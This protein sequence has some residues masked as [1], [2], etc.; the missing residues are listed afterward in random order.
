M[1][2]RIEKLREG[3]HVEIYPVSLQQARLVT[4]SYKQTE[5]EPEVIRRSK[6]LANILD[7]MPI[8]IEEGEL[9]VGNSASKPMGAE[10]SFL[11]GTCSKEQIEELKYEGWG[12]SEEDVAEA[13]QLNEYWRGKGF[14]ARAGHIFDD[15]RM[16]PYMQSG[17]T[18]PPW[19]DR[20][21]GWGGIAGP[22]MS[23]GPNLFLVGTDYEKVLREGLN[24]TIE[25]AKN[26]LRNLRFTTADSAKKVYFLRAV[27]TVHQA[28]IRF[29]H[30]FSRLA[31]E[32]A[33]E[34]AD[35]TRKK[36]LE[37]IAESCRWV[38]ANPA[39]TF[40]EALQS[41]WFAFLL[42]ANQTTPGGRFDQ[43]MYPFYKGDVDGGKITDEQ[44]VELLQCLRIKCMQVI[45][46]PVRREQRDKGAGY[47]RWNNFVIG[48]VT[49]EGKDATNELT[50][51]L[52]E[53]ARTCPTPHHTITLRVHEGT[54][55]ALMV[56]ALEV[57][58]T[59]IGMPAFVGDQSY[60][61]YLLNE[62]VPLEVAR[63]YILVGCLD[64][65]LSRGMSRISAFPM[66]VVPKVFELFLNNGV[67]PR[68]GQQ[69]GPKTGDI[70][71]FESYDELK[72][73]WEQHLTHFLGIHAEWN[74]IFTLMQAEHFPFP[75]ESSLMA[76]G[77][78]V[79]R[80]LMERTFP[81]L[82]NGS[83]MNPVGMINV[84]DS[85]AAIKRVVFDEK[86]VTMKQLKAA[87][88][89]NWQG[90]Q[91]QEIHKM[92]LAVPKFGNDN[93]Y[94]DSI[95]KEMY[96]FWAE[97]TNTFDSVLGGKQKASA[98]SITAHVPG[99]ALTG[100]TPDGRYA[101]ESLAD[102][103]LSPVQ[104]RD[105]LGPTA[106]I[107]SAAKIDQT[108][109]QAALFNMK[110]HPSAMKSTED[111]TK[112]AALIKTYFSMG[113]KHVQFNVVSKETLQ[114]AQKHPEKH[115]DL[116]VRVA[117]YS[118]YFVQLNKTTQEEIIARSEQEQTA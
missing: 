66:F 83:V 116:I 40:A 95:A 13:E 69:L 84:A 61:Q 97:K 74:T 94:V 51:L 78:K 21:E 39:R 101:G 77:I 14:F 113:G 8:F 47:A 110:F 30:R 59:G 111:L 17:V 76:D 85:L 109:Y 22:G 34:E 31:A 104:G 2:Q 57:V 87:L 93:D 9:I 81:L 55:D 38:P 11:L 12:T 96:Q 68:T 42:T 27:I 10:L 28:V 91:N 79:G 115:R 52:L 18:L 99:G 108:P 82:E 25:D 75:L 37:Q 1:N 62:G 103:A 36:E 88:D 100:A 26:G 54:P 86:K 90:E 15:E 72:R 43:F 80:D 45:S 60:I 53:A 89:A 3:L 105:I 29:A 92:C 107:K 67:H 106:V 23:L 20:D 6:A 58:R 4:E 46:I 114:D 65:S 44:V 102:G 48:G 7:K 35:P 64:V 70:D 112:V 56:K 118:A 32:K 19:A 73:A 50:Y 117:G 16:W 63:D 71:S 98:I 33:A 5:G 24:K 41:F 49:P